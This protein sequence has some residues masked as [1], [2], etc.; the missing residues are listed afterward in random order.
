[1]KKF[2]RFNKL[3]SIERLS[4]TDTD[5]TK[6]R[7]STHDGYIAA[8]KEILKIIDEQY[9][10]GLRGVSA[11][12]NVRRAIQ[13]EL[14]TTNDESRET[15]AVRIDDS[16]FADDMKC[17]HEWCWTL[18]SDLPGKQSCHEMHLVQVPKTD[19]ESKNESKQDESKLKS[20]NDIYA[21]YVVRAGHYGFYIG[22]TD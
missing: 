3:W 16:S 8:F 9:K 6:Y 4:Y 11:L 19:N 1:M 18:L 17:E 21:C 2:E 7:S 22:K 20:F 13:D 15:D 5:S 12:E 10:Q 14:G